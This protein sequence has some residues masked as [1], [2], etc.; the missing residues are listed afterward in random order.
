MRWLPTF[1]EF[2]IDDCN[3]PIHH[4][5]EQQAIRFPDAP[6][7][8]LLSGDISYGKLNIA[9][10]RAARMLLA[11]AANDTKPIALMLDQGYESILWTLAILKAG[12]CYAPFDQRLPEPVLRA[13][14]DD[15]APGALIAGTRYRNA[16]RKLAAGR[17]P[18]VCTDTN[19]HQFTPEN[20]DRPSAAESVAYVF[21]TSGSTGTPKGVAD[22]HRN[23]L[24]NVLRYTNS[25]RFAPGDILSLV[26]NPSF[27]GTV[28]SLFGALLN[29]AAIAPFDLQTDGLQTLSQWLRRAQ[30]TVFH[31]VP[32]IFRQL[33]DPV[34]RFPDI[35]LI[36]LEGDRASAL[37]VAHFR[38]NFQDHCTLVNGLGATEC[39]L[40]RQFFIGKDSS[41]Y[42]NEPVP[43]GYPVADTTV[44]IID[45]QGSALPP[46][47]TGEVVVESR[48][49]ATGYWEN[50]ALTAERFVKLRGGLRGYRTGD[51]G[52]MSEDG[53]LFHLGRVDQRMRIAGEFV[54]AVDIEKI[55]LDIPGISQVVV[56]DYFDRCG[57]RRLCAYLVTH[58]DARVTVTALREALSERIA[59]HLVPSTFVF[60]DRLPLTKDLKIDYLGL[61]QPGRQRPSLFNNFIAPRT[62]LEQAMAHLWEVVLEI[63]P[64]GVTDSFFD[65]GGDS[66][67][68]ARFASLLRESRGRVIEVT[69]LFDHRTIG[70]LCH[71][72]ESEQPA[73][74]D[75]LVGS[76]DRSRTWPDHSIAIIG[77][78]GRFP[79][80][81]TLDQFWDNL[82]AARECITFFS[83]TVPQQS[84]TSRP[85]TV[86]ACGLLSDVD[87]FDAALFRLT[88]R[89]AQMLDP[90]QRLWLE[91]VHQALEDAG[92][93]VGEFGYAGDAANIGVFVGGRESTYLWHLVG[94]NRNAVES[95]LHRRGDEAHQLMF[96]NDTD[97]IAARTSFLMG[98]TG[99][100]LNIQTACSTS[101]VAVAQA[102]Q[103]LM[104][105][106]CDLAVAGG[107]AVTF[108]QTR[109][110]TYQ[111]GGIHS[112]DGHCRAFDAAATG[113]V[114]G[115]GVGV[116]VLKRLDDAIS[117][118]DRIDAVIR[119]WA[120][121]N[122]GSDKA[123]FAAPSIDGQA[124]VIRRA[125]DHAGIQ[126][127]DVSYVE[128]H[129]T[130]TPVGDPIEFA[131]LERAFRLG[132]NARGF[133]GLGSVKTNIGHLDAAAGIAGL[134][135]TVLA[136][137]HREIPPTLHFREANPE[138]DLDAS[139][140]YITSSRSS[141]WKAN[142]PRIAGVSA[143]GVGGTNCHMVLQ[144]AAVPMTPSPR[145][146]SSAYLLT[147]SAA[148]EAALEAL[149]DRYKR[150]LADASI[151]DI[152]GIAATTQKSRSCYSYRTAIVG[153]SAEQI[154]NRLSNH[155][156][157][158]AAKGCW[159]GKQKTGDGPEIGFL[160]V[161]QGSQYVG[162]GRQ[163]YEAN[164]DFRR[165]LERCDHIL[166]DQLE[167]PL[168]DVMFADAGASALIH[169]TEY[170]Q[171]ALFAMEYALADLLLSWGIKP[172]SVMGHSIGE[173]AAACIAGVFTLEEGIRLVAARGRIMQQ[174]PGEG[175]MLAIT[176]NRETLDTSLETLSSQVSI[177]AINSPT[178]KVLS[179]EAHAI[180]Q[181]KTM[182][183]TRGVYCRELAVSHAFHSAHMTPALAPL[184]DLISAT[185]LH[186]P[187]LRLIGNL[188]GRAV[189]TE[190]TDPEYWCDHAQQPVLFEAGIRAMIEEGCD[191]FVEI[192]P[193]TVFSLLT[194]EIP[195]KHP[196]ETISTLR[197]G[198][199]DWTA[200][201]ETV[202]RL[203]V[204]GVRL[205]WA[206][207]QEGR[208]FRPIRLPNYPFQRSRY[209]Y[210]GPLVKAEPSATPRE[211]GSSG[212]PLLGRR[213]R[214]PGSTELRFNV[215]FSQTAPHFLGD[216]RLFG[217]SL[218]PAASHFAMLAQASEHL[219][220][221]APN[222]DVSLRF[223]DLYLL[224]PLLLPDGCARD[225]QLIF[226]PEIQGWSLEITSAEAGEDELATAEWTSHM[227]GLGRT[228]DKVKQNLDLIAIQARCPRELSGH[229]FYSSIWANQ[230]GTGSAFRWIESI[231]QGD[232]EALCRAVCPTGIVDASKY[233]LHPGV[234]EAACQLLHCCE[235][236]ETDESIQQTGATY[237]PFSVDAFSLFDVKASHDQAWCHAR[238]YEHSPDD[239]VG[240]LSILN[241][242][243][244]LVARLDGFR[245]RTI[246]CE[247]V[248]P[249]SARTKTQTADRARQVNKRPASGGGLD[250][251]SLGY[252]ELVSY[253]QRRCA[254]LSGY[255]ESE[256]PIDTG[257]LQMGLDSIVAMILSN[258]L[259]RDFDLA[260]PVSQ[261]LTS[262]SIKALARAICGIPS[263]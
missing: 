146:D 112:R 197:R 1:V 248:D 149:E 205:N 47:S 233:R 257:W 15:L 217:V 45:D 191:V 132:T 78:A 154:R 30:V 34:T 108:P 38:Q 237:V 224:R 73:P 138:I 71:A 95:L 101:L 54:A 85:A 201:L 171:P 124:Q 214:L 163:L 262:T 226:R 16:C 189:T 116:V 142:G 203:Y 157:T 72:L 228:S 32:S 59:K 31:S 212:H 3:Q 254:E 13:I 125:Q 111:E 156:E 7:V 161:G 231:W 17:F 121:N 151:P 208:R 140:F 88:P 27:S 20:L 76:E 247:A 107:V 99:P 193:D 216:H 4:R 37:D 255:P 98:F 130:G 90:Q 102:C 230:G 51:L 246:T 118:G 153:K 185:S 186:V 21:Y 105:K 55:L 190:V 210:E 100:S 215:R 240:D 166:H 238:L 77:M 28:S 187:V 8:L 179:G 176:A 94:G 159:R 135:K 39:G 75:D 173:Y 155:R 44:R 168:L 219:V 92:L 200:V 80:A 236:I 174:L 87:R 19:C 40:V 128:A 84:S 117:D 170:A 2:L 222:K 167:R 62:E 109:S 194:Q 181:L 93:P 199:D 61:P 139:P 263:D 204:R 68:A 261:I 106:Q 50:K 198:E 259:R 70:A 150:F 11:N 79:G 235:I 183:E 218:P 66:L 12:L 220:D 127:H 243:G 33:S 56:R 65:L 25:L 9:A 35:R 229:E 89:Q 258:G 126:P 123:S 5:F 256:I 114:F 113:T 24:H 115:D 241:G 60:L 164:A 91:C 46:G 165:T 96:S 120:V 86:A 178:Q 152:A 245:L 169:R 133:C 207:F 242:S 250:K 184:R 48:F 63:K 53:C 74:L 213:F 249:A 42:G 211:K 177:A 239:V 253:L 223:E 104:S 131:G 251:R 18:V 160:F 36:R 134:I 43:V 6:A 69:S 52:R 188:H 260:V 182:L 244:E 192:G 97:S 158:S 172:R 81:D 110:Y 57:E 67:R 196:T 227:I 10:N 234:I 49:L 83:N 225:V 103:G 58:G 162:M 180:D 137:K 119:G 175:K 221:G 145:S 209:W 195:S 22:S 144:E 23:V 26:Q 29:G 64:V 252:E 232:R 148:S 141:P 147:L 202:A 206:A 122:D 82:R 14:V 136:L 143:F 129:G 41:F